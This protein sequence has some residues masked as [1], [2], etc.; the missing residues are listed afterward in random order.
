MAFLTLP[1]T[2]LTRDLRAGTATAGDEAFMDVGWGIEGPKTPQAI[3]D[4]PTA[5]RDGGEG[6]AAHL[7]TGKTAHAAQLDAL[8][9][10]VVIGLHRSDEWDL[11]LGAAPAFT[12]PFA[13]Q[14]GIIDLDAP[15]ERFPLVTIV[16]DLQQL[17]LELPS[18]VVADAE[19]AGPLINMPKQ[20]SI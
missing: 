16:H 5:G 1:S 6:I 12:R 17:V 20:V 14:V 7:D 2:V 9:M 8:R 13:A 18:G 10:A 3:A 15:G 11:V 19:L 4:H